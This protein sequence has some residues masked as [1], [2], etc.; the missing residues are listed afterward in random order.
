MDPRTVLAIHGVFLNIAA[1]K[2]TKHLIEARPR[3]DEVRRG[4]ESTSG[5]VPAIS[6]TCAVNSHIIHDL[7][8]RQ[9]ARVFND[10]GQRVEEHVVL[11]AELGMAVADQYSCLGYVAKAS[12]W[13]TI[14]CGT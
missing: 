11:Q 13:C 1:E 2:R 14:G 9:R 6:W 8:V 5:V 3:K 12:N 7:L 4:R 10:L